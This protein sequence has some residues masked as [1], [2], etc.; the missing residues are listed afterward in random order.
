MYF[1]TT[2]FKV[3]ASFL[4]RPCSHDLFSTRTL[5]KLLLPWIRHF[6][7]IISAKWLRTISKFTREEVKHQSGGKLGMRSTSKG[8]RIRPKN[9]RHR[10]FLVE[11]SNNTIL[12]YFSRENAVDCYHNCQGFL[13]ARTQQAGREIVL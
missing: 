10:R 6:A 7:M 3:K 12:V 5:V 1:T 9:K 4:R 11:S 2:S 8:A 13:S